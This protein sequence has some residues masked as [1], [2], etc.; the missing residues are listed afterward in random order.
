MD[1]SILAVNRVTLRRGC[2][3]GIHVGKLLAA[4]TDVLLDIIVSNGLAASQLSVFYWILCVLKLLCPR[5]LRHP[6]CPSPRWPGDAGC[7]S[8]GLHPLIVRSLRCVRQGMNVS[9]SQIR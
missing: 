7:P 5:Y 4:Q 6:D 2:I 1:A 8:S 9:K 3:L